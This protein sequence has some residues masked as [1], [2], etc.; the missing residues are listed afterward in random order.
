MYLFVEPVAPDHRGVG[1]PLDG[2]GPLA[3]VVNLFG[4]PRGL[5]HRNGNNLIETGR[6]TFFIL[7]S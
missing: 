7:L 5:K 4:R 3:E 1:V 2:V 6:L